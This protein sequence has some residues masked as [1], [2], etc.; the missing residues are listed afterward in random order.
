MKSLLRALLPTRSAKSA[1][2]PSRVA[3]QA[4]PELELLERREVPTVTNYGGALLQKVEVQG[5]Y[6]GSDWFSSPYLAQKNYLDGFLGNIVNSS[7]MDMLNKEGY[8]VGRG[9]ASAGQIYG[10]GLNKGLYL[11]DAQIRNYLMGCINAGALKAPDAN[12]LYVVFVEDNVVVGDANSNSNNA[13][14]G[15]HGAFS[16]TVDVIPNVP[17]WTY[18]ADIHYAVIPYAGGANANRWWLNALDTITLSTSHELAEAV[19]DPNV[20]YKSLA[21]YDSGR[22][23]IGDISN[24]QTVYLNGYA[25]QREA[26]KNDQSM[27]PAGATGIHAVNFVLQKNGNLYETYGNGLIFLASGVASLSDQGID[28][29]GHAMVD[30]VFSNGSADEYHEGLNSWTYL[31]SGVKQAVAGQGV[32]YV[33]YNSG[34]VYELKDWGGWTGPLSYNATSIS[35]GTDR[36]GV[37]M[38]AE[39]WY[40]EVWEYSDSSGWHY[41]DSGVKAVSAGQQGIID[42]LTTGGT[43]IWY[44]EAGGVKVPLASGVA[45]VTAGTDQYGN[46]MIDLLLTNGNLYE[47]R[48][49]GV[50]TWLDNGVQSIGKGHHGVVDIVFT[51]SDAWTHDSSGW[52]FLSSNARTAA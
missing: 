28:N 46:Y 3:R 52:H 25:V 16:G 11:S 33:L 29:Y 50:W 31:G 20:N 19:T 48:V 10:I 37:S 34:T 42:Y 30:V 5:M 26:D 43:A 18:Q 6:L 2:S 39:V 45:Q 44:S 14:L 24:A 13:F 49:G 9:S 1:K 35:A 27:T 4:R 17:L 32:S 40:G 21:W 36:Y 22:G 41:I 12:R 23:E 8:G 38:L 47:Y 51:W 7:Y 15:Y